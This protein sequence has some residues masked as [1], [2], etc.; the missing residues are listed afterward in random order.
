MTKKCRTGE[1]H[2]TDT[3]RSGP[4]RRGLHPRPNN[5]TVIWMPT[6]PSSELGQW[7]SHPPL[8]RPAAPGAQ[9]A[10]NPASPD[11]LSRES[12]QRRSTAR[13]RS[14]PQR[15]PLRALNSPQRPP[16]RRPDSCLYIIASQLRAIRKQGLN[17]RYGISHG[18]PLIICNTICHTVTHARYLYLERIHIE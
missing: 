4:E 12:L 8:P 10:F 16:P 2:R 11:T 1:S 6:V 7:A 18:Y 5:P 9:F 13:A 17:E 15:V 14:H 3:G